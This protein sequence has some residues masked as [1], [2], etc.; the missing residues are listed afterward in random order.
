MANLWRSRKSYLLPQ[1]RICDSAIVK[2]KLCGFTEKTSLLAAIEA[3]CD[4]IGFVFYEKSPRFIGVDSASILAKQIPQKIAKVAVVVDCDFDFLT[5]I[6]TKFIPDFFQ[7]HGQENADFLREVKKK[8]PQIKIIKA[9]RILENEDLKQAK[10][11]EDIVDL[12]LFDS[13]NPGSGKS[14]KW[15]ILKNFSSKK[16]WFLSGGLNSNNIDSAIEISGAR[17]IDL[18]SGIEELRGQ[19]SPKLIYELM[20]KVRKNAA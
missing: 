2:V 14:F 18:S 4:F 3:G 12:F 8:F 9:L 7:F 10:E 6:S 17:M 11:F 15:E 5:E 19:K 16:N 13:A 20:A 1:K